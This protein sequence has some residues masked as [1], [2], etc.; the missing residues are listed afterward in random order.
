MN[1]SKLSFLRFWKFIKYIF[2]FKA[3]YIEIFSIFLIVL[4]MGLKIQCIGHIKS[5]L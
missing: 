2:I 5:F 3:S 4:G 1:K